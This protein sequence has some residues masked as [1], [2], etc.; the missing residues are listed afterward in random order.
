[1]WNL[2][3]TVVRA[4]SK[5][6]AW[7][8]GGL[9]MVTALIICADIVLR[10]WFTMSLP[11]TDELAGYALAIAAAWALSFALL[12]RAHIRI[13]SIYILLSRRAQSRL[14]LLAVLLMLIFFGLITYHGWI[15]LKQSIAVGTRSQSELA[16]VLAYPQALWVGGL[17]FFLVSCVVVLGAASAR[18]FAGDDRGVRELAGAKTVGEELAEEAASL[19]AKIPTAEK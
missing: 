7:M 3:L 12:E 17:A 5:G 18:Y 16:M 2:P 15:A 13:D 4:V 14:D 8:G 10:N 6:A 19:G 1:M 9:L 11:G